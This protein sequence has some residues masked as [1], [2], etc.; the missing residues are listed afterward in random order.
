MSQDDLIVN[1]LSCYIYK[2]KE[3]ITIIVDYLN[4]LSNNNCDEH[5]NSV[6]SIE[7]LIEE[8]DYLKGFHSCIIYYEKLTI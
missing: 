8:I 2:I 6:N 1:S 4:P 5:D 3:Y 7:E